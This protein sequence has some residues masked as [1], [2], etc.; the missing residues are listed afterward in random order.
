MYQWVGKG[1]PEEK[2]IN[3]IQVSGSF[4]GEKVE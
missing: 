3:I 4:K 2:E 1:I